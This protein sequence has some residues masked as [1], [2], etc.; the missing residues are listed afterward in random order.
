MNILGGI[1][2]ALMQS[3][4]RSTLYCLASCSFAQKSSG[5]GWSNTSNSLI[6]SLEGIS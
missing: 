1:S 3:S 5:S 2:T 6:I 4:Y